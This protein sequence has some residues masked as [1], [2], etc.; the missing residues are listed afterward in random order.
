MATNWYRQLNEDL[1]PILLDVDTIQ[2]RVLELGRQITA[3][4]TRTAEHV[5][6]RVAGSVSVLGFRAPSHRILLCKR[7]GEKAG[8][9]P[10]EQEISVAPTSEGGAES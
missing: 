5:L 4:Q 9:G 3:D 2:S 1:G 7:P 10:A 6:D 8:A